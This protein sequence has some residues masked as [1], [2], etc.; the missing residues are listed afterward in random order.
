VGISNAAAVD[1]AKSALSL[2][3]MQQAEDVAFEN[4]GL[5]DEARQRFSYAL[6]MS[7]TLEHMGLI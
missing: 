2:R 3:R 6:I 5:P 1:V 7:K 4:S